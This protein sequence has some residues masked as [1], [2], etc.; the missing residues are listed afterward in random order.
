ME[1][2]VVAAEITDSSWGIVLGNLCHLRAFAAYQSHDKLKLKWSAPLACAAHLATCVGESQLRLLHNSAA[3]HAS[4]RWGKCISRSRSRSRGKMIRK[5]DKPGKEQQPQPQ[6]R[7]QKKKQKPRC[8]QEDL[9]GNGRKKGRWVERKVESSKGKSS[10]TIRNTS[11]E[12][13]L[14]AL[15]AAPLPSPFPR[16]ST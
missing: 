7:Q 5:T 4:N 2:A 10:Q 16:Q 13:R 15:R 6:G 3:A 14:K 1:Q 12:R 8:P 9:E 11:D